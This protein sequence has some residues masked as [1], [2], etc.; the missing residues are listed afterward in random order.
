MHSFGGKTKT[1]FWKIRR[2]LDGRIMLKW[3]LQNW[4]VKVCETHNR[5][6]LEVIRAYLKKQKETINGSVI[7]AVCSTARFR[8]RKCTFNKWKS[9]PVTRE[10]L[11]IIHLENIYTLLEHSSPLVLYDDAFTGWWLL[12]RNFGTVSCAAASV[13]TVVFVFQPGVCKLYLG[14]P[15]VQ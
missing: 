8:Q 4:N 15:W 2:S 1:L 9:R 10:E 13:G 7:C 6:F 11:W 14:S 3:I 12:Q 5:T